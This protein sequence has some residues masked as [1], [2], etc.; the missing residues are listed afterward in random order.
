MQPTNSTDPIQYRIEIQKVPNEHFGTIKLY[1]SSNTV[2][3]A[4]VTM[5]KN[6][7]TDSNVVTGDLVEKCLMM[8]IK[9]DPNEQTRTI[10]GILQNEFNVSMNIDGKKIL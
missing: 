6:T 8:L 9:A 1:D 7:S 4:D 10:I 2:I 3:S 5:I